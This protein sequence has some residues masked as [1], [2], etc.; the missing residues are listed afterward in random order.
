MGQE[1]LPAATEALRNSVLG[2]WGQPWVGLFG[3]SP[4]PLQ[5][6]S[7]PGLSSQALIWTRMFMSPADR[8]VLMCPSRGSARI[9]PKTQSDPAW[10]LKQHIYFKAQT[11]KR[12]SKTYR[13]ISKMLFKKKKSKS[14][15]SK[16]VTLQ[17]S[18]WAV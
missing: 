8:A 11:N 16:G 7:C 9:S 6:P 10:V 17:H 18:H 13:N 15:G 2:S 14:V 3:I 5:G 12:F 4:V 1:V